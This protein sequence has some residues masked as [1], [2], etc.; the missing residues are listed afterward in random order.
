MYTYI[1]IYI[2]IHLHTHTPTHTQYTHTTHTKHTHSPAICTHSHDSTQT[3]PFPTVIGRFGIITHPPENATPPKPTKSRNITPRYKFQ[4]NQC[5]NLNLYREIPGN[6]SVS[7]WWILGGSI[8]RGLTSPFRSLNSAEIG[9]TLFVSTGFL[10]RGLVWSECLTSDY[11]IVIIV[12]WSEC[13]T[14]WT[15]LYFR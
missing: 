12:V 5:F 9:C 11:R 8:F 2:H 7:I 15:L 4:S 3:I 1:Q 6:L 14:Y 10:S 13:L